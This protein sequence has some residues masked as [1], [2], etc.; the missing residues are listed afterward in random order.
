M[1][2]TNKIFGKF[3][4][5]KFHT[6]GRRLLAIAFVML[7]GLSMA[8]CKDDL[9]DNSKTKQDKKDQTSSQTPDP[10]QD[11]GPNLF[12]GEWEGYIVAS[13]YEDMGS[14]YVELTILEGGWSLEVYGMG[15]EGE[16]CTYT[17][18]G[19]VMTILHYG[20]EKGTCT[21]NADEELEIRLVDDG[22]GLITGTLTRKTSESPALTFTVSFK[23][24]EDAEINMED[25][26]L[27]EN[28]TATV[29]IAETFAKYE[30][31]INNKPA[32][33]ALVSNNGKTITLSGD[34]DYFNIGNNRL[35]V[36]VTTS[37]GVIYSKTVIFTV[38]IE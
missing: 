1:K 32:P 26:V 38:E 13:A 16:H 33:E 6:N 3:C 18:N 22:F 34:G 8:V 10:I 30:W 27:D 37:G 29:T 12:I 23:N 9:D 7:I 31:Y 11:P 24:A 2:N 19:K 5:A 20:E 35:S 25:F 21:L 14:V 36:K 4:T 17:W 15:D 28:G